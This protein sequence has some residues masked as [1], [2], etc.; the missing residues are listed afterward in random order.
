MAQLEIL[1][2][3]NHLIAINK[4]AGDLSQGDRTG[5]KTLVHDVKT[6]LASKYHKPGQVFL[7]VIHRLDR[8]VTGVI[9]FARTSKAL[10]RCNA[11]LRNHA[12]SKT[13]WAV[14]NGQL[15]APSG[16]LTDY[17]RKDA[18]T[19]ISYVVPA[20]EAGARKAVLHYRV[21]RTI[22][23]RH[24]VEV[25]LETGR[26]HQIRVQ[27]AHAGAVVDGDVKYGA[28]KPMPDGSILLHARQLA[29]EHPVSKQM[30]NIMAPVPTL[31][32]WQQMTT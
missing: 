22:G 24:L 19:N 2:E 17:L 8:P 3:D 28:G 7:G 11:M 20:S 15:K 32:N 16:T 21:L 29:F 27:L 9:L 14:V 25:Q 23:S 30:V 5:D 10:E 1:F 4:R 31:A 18:A 26:P 12:F 13:Y 6:Y